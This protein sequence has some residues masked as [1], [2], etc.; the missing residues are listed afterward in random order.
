MIRRPPRSTLFPYTTLFRSRTADVQDHVPRLILR[1]IDTERHL[2]PPSRIRLPDD[3]AQAFE[4]LF[5]EMHDAQVEIKFVFRRLAPVKPQWNRPVEFVVKLLEVVKDLSENVF[6]GKGLHRVEC[7][8]GIG[9]HGGVSAGWQD[10][11][12]ADGRV[13]PEGGVNTHLPAAG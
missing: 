7:R 2:G 11:D 8:R 10:K 9:S 3:F 6:S 1:R 13:T 12:G 5:R 4:V